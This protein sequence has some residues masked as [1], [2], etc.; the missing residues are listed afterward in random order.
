MAHSLTLYFAFICPLDGFR[1]LYGVSPLPTPSKD[2]YPL[3]S[4]FLDRF[5]FYPHFLFYR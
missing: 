3:Y 1:G 2:V 5:R 4:G